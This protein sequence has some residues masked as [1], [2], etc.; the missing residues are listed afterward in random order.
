M[1]RLLIIQPDASD[2]VGPLGE[3]FAEAGAELDVRLM[4]EQRLPGGLDGYAGVVC[5]GG[6]MGALDD[7][8]HP[9]LAGVR[10]MLASAAGKRVPTLGVCL[11]A[12]LLAAATGGQVVVGEDG[13]EVGPALVSKKDAAWRDP[14]FADLPLVPDVLQFHNDVIKRVPPGAEILA[15]APR[16]PHQAF[17]LNRCAYGIQFHIET[18]PDLVRDWAKSA[19]EMA[20]LTRPGAL[21]DESLTELHADLAET[22]RPFAHRFVRLAAGELEPAAEGQHRLPLV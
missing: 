18:T 12:Q 19:P 21:S 22:W 9:W 1:T 13:P 3:W 2:P 11:G 16:Y 15:S 20:E 5:L 10:K 6:S 17:R 14:L 7:A 4:P 8:D